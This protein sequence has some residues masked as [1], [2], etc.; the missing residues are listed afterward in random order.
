M[1]YDFPLGGGEPTT[2]TTTMPATTTTPANT[3]TPASTD[4]QSLPAKESEFHRWSNK[5]SDELL[6]EVER[7]LA[8]LDAN[9]N[10]KRERDTP[11][12][13]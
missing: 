9:K 8:K 3:N 2:A 7:V 1:L 13:Q 5:D 10:M 12:H 11:T 4:G 6:L